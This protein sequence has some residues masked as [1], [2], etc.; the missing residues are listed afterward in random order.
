MSESRWLEVERM[1]TLWVN[2]SGKGK[3]L[4]SSSWSAIFRGRKRGG[5]PPAG[6]PASR[7]VSTWNQEP[8]WDSNSFVKA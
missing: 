2:L 6:L 3:A 1:L 7:L 4:K 5:L 8:F